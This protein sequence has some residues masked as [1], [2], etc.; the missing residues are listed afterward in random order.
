MKDNSETNYLN[1][2]L[3][4][5]EVSDLPSLGKLEILHNEADKDENPQLDVVNKSE[6]LIQLRKDIPLP[7]TGEIEITSIPKRNGKYFHRSKAHQKILPNVDG[8]HSCNQCD[9]KFQDIGQL[10]LHKSIHGD[11]FRC[12]FCNMSFKSLQFLRRHNSMCSKGIT[13]KSI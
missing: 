2:D 3:S 10:L 8:S 6:L 12:N 1:Y 9:K 13:F 11:Y 7:K 4:L 5:I